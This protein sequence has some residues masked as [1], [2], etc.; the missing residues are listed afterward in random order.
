MRV[1][2]L[3]DPAVQVKPSTL[4]S[5]PFSPSNMEMKLEPTDPKKRRNKSPTHDSVLIVKS[6]PPWDFEAS[7]EKKSHIEYSIDMTAE[8]IIQLCK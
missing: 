1:I 2:F 3:L 5:G 6:E 4:S 8:T 7:A